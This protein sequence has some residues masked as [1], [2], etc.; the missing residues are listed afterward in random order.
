[1]IAPLDRNV[2]PLA[3]SPSPPHVKRVCL[4][5]YTLG[6]GGG[7]VMSWPPVPRMQEP[8]SVKPHWCTSRCGKG[9]EIERVRKKLDF[10]NSLDIV[11]WLTV[12]TLI[13]ST[14][15]YL[16]PHAY[17]SEWRPGP[18]IKPN[19]TG[20]DVP[21]KHDLIYCKSIFVSPENLVS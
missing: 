2:E 16:H 5:K 20:F 14:Q 6:L 21:L 10:H 15:I 17:L 12:R 8:L 13:R 19:V 1:M 9:I 18:R 3:L 11:K 7:W 4:F